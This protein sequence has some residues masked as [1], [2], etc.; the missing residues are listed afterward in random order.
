MVVSALAV[1]IVACSRA[2]VSTAPVPVVMAPSDSLPGV[3]ALEFAAHD[4]TLL[5]AVARTI[6]DTFARFSPVRV[7]SQPLPL[8]LEART[9][10]AN[11]HSTG[12]GDVDS[13]MADLHTVA[14][15]AA[16]MHG[17]SSGFAVSGADDDPAA[18]S[19]CPKHEYRL[20]IF[21]VPRPG[22]PEGQSLNPNRPRLGLGPDAWA[23]RVVESDIGPHGYSI[24]A[25]DYVYEKRPTGWVYLG[26]V[27]YW[28]ID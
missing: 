1:G 17:C 14:L 27:G 12:R 2:P 19:G 6:V 15:R 21:G 20:V 16:H 18:S 26:W 7:D 22:P 23:V 13:L 4:T 28:F 9:V 5:A 8:S 10:R 25:G 3:S 24:Q 11:A